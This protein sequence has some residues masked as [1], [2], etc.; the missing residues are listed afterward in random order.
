[1]N[2]DGIPAVI[3]GKQ[4][5]KRNRRPSLSRGDISPVYPLFS[6]SAQK[7]VAADAAPLAWAGIG[8]SITV[9]FESQLT[10]RTLFLGLRRDFLERSDHETDIAGELL[11]RN[12][13][14]R[15][16]IRPLL[17]QRLNPGPAHHAVFRKGR[18]PAPSIAIL[19]A[20]GHFIHFLLNTLLSPV[21][22]LFTDAVIGYRPHRSATWP[23][24]GS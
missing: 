22:K 3:K 12:R 23:K 16:S 7:S 18:E 19:P 15:N 17:D 6:C 9:F 21:D 2:A 1:M 10:D 8:S 24:N 11:A 4:Y 13:R 5:L 20:E 14:K